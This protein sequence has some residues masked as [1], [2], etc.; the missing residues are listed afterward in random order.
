V[1]ILWDLAQ[2]RERLRF[3]YPSGT[4]FV[5]CLAL[6]PDGRVV[7]TS[8]G[9]YETV[10]GGQ[11]VDFGHSGGGPFH[12]SAT[13]G[14]AFSADGMR[15]AV[16]HAQGRPFVCDTATWRVVEEADYRP[17]QFISVSF[18]PDGQQLVTGE[19]GGIV[20]LWK[21]HPLS[22]IAV[23]GE[24]AA[25][26]KSVAFSPDG[27]HVVSAGDDKM[28]ALWDVAS[29]KL[30]TRIGLHTAPVYAVAF[31]PDGRRLIS[32]EH[33][34]SVRLYSRHRTLWGFRLD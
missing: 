26:I 30:I 25:R 2:Q 34:H 12:P 21:A 23:I 3:G 4:K 11:L 9:A 32:G 7:V 5:Y 31:S 1:I 19:D 24:H 14:L 8:H 13:Y 20:Q 10:T 17:R 27:K 6:S 15:L 18:S 29:R 28:I 33:D 22:P 16:A